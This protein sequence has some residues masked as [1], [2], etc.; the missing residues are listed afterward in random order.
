MPGAVNLSK[1]SR[2]RC[3]VFG[4]E[5]TPISFLNERSVKLLFKSAA[6][7][8]HERPFFVQWTVTAQTFT[9]DQRGKVSDNGVLSHKWGHRQHTQPFQGLGT[10]T[11]KG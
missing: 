5:S 6:L 11:D 3:S 4:G 7:S 2:S 9:A 8:P 1:N 10:P